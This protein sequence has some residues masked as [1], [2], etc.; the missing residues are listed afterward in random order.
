MDFTT[1]G[2]QYHGGRDRDATDGTREGTT[3]IE[4]EVGVGLRLERNIVVDF[5]TNRAGADIGGSPLGNGGIDVAT[6]AGKPIF[7]TI[8]EVTDIVDAAAGRDHLHQRTIYAI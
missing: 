2:S 7:S 1:E 5:S 4:S 3:F 8:A 6:V